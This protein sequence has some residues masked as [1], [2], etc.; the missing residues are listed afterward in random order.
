MKGGG[1]KR[2]KREREN[3]KKR[4]WKIRERAKEQR[5]WPDLYYVSVYCAP[6]VLPQPRIASYTF[7]R[8]CG[9][10]HGK[11]RTYLG[12]VVVVVVERW[13]PSG[14]VLFLP[15]L[16]SFFLT[17]L[18]LHSLFILIR[19]QKQQKK[20]PPPHSLPPTHPFLARKILR[21][22]T[23]NKKCT[24]AVTDYVLTS[25]IFHSLNG[26]LFISIPGGDC[27]CVCAGHGC[28]H[29]NDEQQTGRQVKSIYTIMHLSIQIYLYI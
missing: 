16:C 7:S 29:W 13:E 3:E 25:Q 18:F 1:G 4:W 21:K 28:V 23:W 6:R 9:D 12:R 15:L 24:S 8:I 14:F 17:F 19:L 11:W 20:A 27:I 2:N 22:R 26:Y 10:T 5:P